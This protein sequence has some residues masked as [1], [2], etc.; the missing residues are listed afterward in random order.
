MRL[1]AAHSARLTRRSWCTRR[2]TPAWPQCATTPDR[3]SRSRRRW[4]SQRSCAWRR[5]AADGVPLRRLPL[6]PRLLRVWSAC[7]QALSDDALSVEN[8]V[9]R[10]LLPP[11][12]LTCRHTVGVQVE[13]GRDVRMPDVGRERLRV[14]RL[15]TARAASG[16]DRVGTSRSRRSRRRRDVPSQPST[17]T[18]GRDGSPC[19]RPAHRALGVHRSGG[20]LVGQGRCRAIGRQQQRRRRV[21]PA[22]N[23]A[24][25]GEVAG[26]A[27][28]RR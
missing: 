13:L 10:S 5:G 4:P 14:R 27:G 15:E 3:C 17:S 6:G 21:L 19:R 2:R 12:A 23:C 25:Q 20:S 26:D 22:A 28:E 11:T 18:V 16:Q 7:D 24:A 8:A 9:E 1:W